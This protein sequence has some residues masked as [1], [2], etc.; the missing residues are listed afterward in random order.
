MQTE[1]QS[2]MVK[3]NEF[4]RA[5]YMIYIQVITRSGHLY[6]MRDNLLSSHQGIFNRDNSAGTKSLYTTI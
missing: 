1:N 3:R 4:I 5:I 6:S 2:V